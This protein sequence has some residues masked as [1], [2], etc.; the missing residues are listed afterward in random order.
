M[1]FYIGN[2]YIKCFQ[3]QDMKEI[4]RELKTYQSISLLGMYFSPYLILWV[5]VGGPY[6]HFLKTET[7]LYKYNC[8]KICKYFVYFVYD[9]VILANHLEILNICILSFLLKQDF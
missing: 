1:K 4:M 3:D 2:S 8:S 9:L 7:W 5:D 6:V